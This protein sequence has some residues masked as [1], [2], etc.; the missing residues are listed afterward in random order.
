ML[1]PLILIYLAVGVVFIFGILTVYIINSINRRDKLLSEKSS[2]LK[3]HEEFQ[4]LH[5]RDSYFSKRD[6]NKWKT[7]WDGIKELVVSYLHYE[8]RI[9]SSLSIFK[10]LKSYLHENRDYLFV[11]EAFRNILEDISDYLFYGLEIVEERNEEYIKNELIAY[12]DFFNDFSGKI[13]TPKQRRSVIVDEANNL[14]IAGAGTGKTLTITAKAGYLIRKGLAEPEDLL[15]LSF[16]KDAQLEMETRIKRNLD[17]NVE[18]RTFH[19]LGYDIIK[20]ATGERPPISE[21]ANDKTARA[22]KLND[23]MQIFLKNR[24]G[25]YKFLNLVNKY[26]SYYLHP[27]ENKFNFQSMEEYEEYLHTVELRTLQGE[28][29][30]SYEESMIANFLFLNGI[31]YVYEELYDYDTGGEPYQPDFYLSEF[32]VWIEHYGIDREGNTAPNVNKDEY[33]KKMDWK[34]KTHNENNTYC[35]ETFSYENQEDVLIP[36][37]IEKLHVVGVDL[38]PIPNDEIFKKISTLGEVTFFIGL[39]SK[40]LNLYKSANIT[41]PSLRKKTQNYLHKKR[42]D[43]FLDIFEILYEDYKSHLK[44]TGRIDFHDMINQATQYVEKGDYFPKVKYIL[45]D[46]YQ[47]ISQSRYRFLKSILKQNEDCTLFCV[48][49]D[50]QSIYRFTGSD[51]SLMTRFEKYFDPFEILYLNKT[52]RFNDSIENVSSTFIMKNKNQR[53]KFLEADNVEENAVTLIWYNSQNTAIKKALEIINTTV[54]EPVDV[55]ILGRYGTRFYR[56]IEKK[57]FNLKSNAYQQTLEGST[58]SYISSKNS[59]IHKSKGTEADYVILLGLHSRKYGFPCDIEDDPV[60]RLVLS[61]DEIFPFAEERRVFYAGITRAKKGVFLLADSDA[62]SP[63]IDELVNDGYPITIL[64]NPRA[65]PK[66]QEGF[67]LSNPDDN[68]IINCSRCSYTTRKCPECN[69]YLILRQGTPDFYGCSNYGKTGCTYKENVSFFSEEQHEV[70]KSILQ[71]K[72]NQKP[73]NYEEEFLHY[74]ETKGVVNLITA[75]EHL[76]LYN[77]GYDEARKKIEKWVTE[78]KIE[79]IGFQGIRLTNE[80]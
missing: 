44:D 13:L 43:A 57:Y 31:N 3:A 53:E 16:G 17:L 48:G 15:L 63:F 21:L 29:V 67:L 50:W 26:F 23:Q 66:C 25:D 55:Y 18:V 74:L 11:E 80:K 19:S 27:V 35:I 68:S 5:N 1:D 40:F 10:F 65:C 60:L 75:T 69:G 79:K 64:E 52:F 34:R 20:K 32:N 49:D 54:K 62:K 28:K 56:D 39:V 72:S 37:L 73:L 8:E 6:F 61:E 38:N 59:T 51:L 9:I 47:D 36:N 4:F 76:T 70:G 46:E 45:V 78:G 42:Y 71:P 77:F 33:L 12:E 7:E 30:K 58:L 2:I 41:I 22:K 24:I 14:V